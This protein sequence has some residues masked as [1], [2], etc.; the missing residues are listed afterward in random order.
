MHPEAAV[1][2]L[3][4]ITR[5]YERFVGESVVSLTPRRLSNDL[6]KSLI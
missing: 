5:Q 2:K 3:P 6:N 4:P 1:A